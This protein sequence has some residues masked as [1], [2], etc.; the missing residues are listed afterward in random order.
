[1]KIA[2]KD[3]K[4]YNIPTVRK[5]LKTDRNNR[6]AALEMGGEPPNCVHAGDS[7]PLLKFSVTC[8]Q[9]EGK[10]VHCIYGCPTVNIVQQLLLWTIVASTSTKFWKKKKKRGHW[11]LAVRMKE[12]VMRLM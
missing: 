4:R 12:E 8:E 10:N 5:R 7:P 1:M 9:L 3:T 11:C 6:S 2:I